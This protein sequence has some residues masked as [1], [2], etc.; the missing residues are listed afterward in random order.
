M[1]S[2][3]AD[4]TVHLQKCIWP[5]PGSWV[6]MG[7][8]QKPVFVLDPKYAY[9]APNDKTTLCHIQPSFVMPGKYIYLGLSSIGIKTGL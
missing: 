5:E 8:E 4:D 6:V 9:G 1:I 3:Y 2:K 7:A